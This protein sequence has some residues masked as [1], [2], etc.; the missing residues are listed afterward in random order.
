M[1]REKLVD[2]LEFDHHFAFDQKI[3]PVGIVDHQFLVGNGAE[4]LFFK[5]QLAQVELMGESPLIG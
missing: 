4:F 3:K 2:R 1:D 5:T